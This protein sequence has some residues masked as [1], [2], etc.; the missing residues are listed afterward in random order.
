MIVQYL[1]DPYATH[2][3]PGKEAT[4][5]NLASLQSELMATLPISQIELDRF[6]YPHEVV[7]RH[8][9][10][11]SANLELRLRKQSYR[12]LQDGVFVCGEVKIGEHVVFDT[13]GARF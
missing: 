5:R 13:R 4:P 10:T 2:A 12:E 7:S 8:L 6:D 3:I 1:L 9:E 11:I